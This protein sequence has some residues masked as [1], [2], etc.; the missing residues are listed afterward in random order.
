MFQ[1]ILFVVKGAVN[2]FGLRRLPSAHGLPMTAFSASTHSSSFVYSCAR[3]AFVA[4]FPPS[5]LFT[6]RPAN[7]PFPKPV[8]SFL[9]SAWELLPGALRP[10]PES[11][12]A[13]T[14]SKISWSTLTRG[15]ERPAERCL[16]WSVGTR[17]KSGGRANHNH[18]WP[19]RRFASLSA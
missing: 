14:E 13:C 18:G 3:R 10:S 1:A 17:N 6:T 11:S 8:T 2:G 19:S 9:R 15:A 12:I 4:G 7:H 5:C 16:R